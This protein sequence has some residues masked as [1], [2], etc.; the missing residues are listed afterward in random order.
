M[1]SDF[2][3]AH[4]ESVQQLRQAL[5]IIKESAIQQENETFDPTGTAN[6]HALSDADIDG[7]PSELGTS[8]RGHNTLNSHTEGTSM[9]SCLL[10]SDGED[11]RANSASTSHIAYTVTADGS[12][13]GLET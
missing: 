2:D 3:L 7:I 9:G 1:A 11:I 12:P 5:D 13:R 6:L 8:P 10:P 4:A